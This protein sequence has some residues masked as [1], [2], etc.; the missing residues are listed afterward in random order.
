MLITERFDLDAARSQA[1]ADWVRSGGHLL[2]A[3]GR[4]ASNF[5]KTSPALASW[6]PV[7]IEGATKLRDL[8]PIESFCRQSSR[9]MGATD[10]PLDAAKLNAP[11]GKELIPSLAGPLVVSRG[12]RTGPRHGLRT[13]SEFAAA[14]QLERV[15]PTWC[16]DCSTSTRTTRST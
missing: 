16:S 6:L 7:K 10:E 14:G 9:I 12:V 1:L 15:R 11:G 2:L 3:I 13:R 4:D 8:S 5:A